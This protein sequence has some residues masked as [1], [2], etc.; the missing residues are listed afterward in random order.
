MRHFMRGVAVPFA[1]AFAAVAGPLPAPQQVDIPA[2]NLTR[3]ARLYK[4]DGDGPFPT[5]IA[6]HGCGGLGGHSEAVQARY[7]DWAEQ[8]GQDGQAVLL[9]GSYGS[10]DLGPQCRVNERTVRGPRERGADRAA[11]RT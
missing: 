9:A 7:R 6:L 8:L 11:G 4:P 1:L 3:H 5:V 2:A 10:R